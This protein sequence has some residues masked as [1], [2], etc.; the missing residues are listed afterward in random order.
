MSRQRQPHQHRDPILRV[1]VHLRLPRQVGWIALG[2]G[3]GNIPRLGD[4]IGTISHVINAL[5]K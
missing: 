3:L 4:L 5:P 2:I 1:T